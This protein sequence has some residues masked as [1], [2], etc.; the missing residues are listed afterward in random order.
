M[1]RPSVFY[2]QDLAVYVS[3]V[4]SGICQI[5]MNAGKHSNDISTAVSIEV[6]NLDLIYTELEDTNIRI[7][8]ILSHLNGHSK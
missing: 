5:R 4:N 8:F 3:G 1:Y 7:A 2:H 6:D